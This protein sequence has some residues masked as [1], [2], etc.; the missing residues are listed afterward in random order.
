ME[1][2]NICELRA[3]I[4]RGLL[5]EA[6]PAYLKSI[7]SLVPSNAPVM[8]VRVPKIRQWVRDFCQANP[9]LTLHQSIGL[10]DLAFVDNVREE[11]LFGILLLGKFEKALP[12][13]LWQTIDRWVAKLE[14][15][16]SCDQLAMNVAASMVAKNLDLVDDLVTWAGAPQLWR[17][18]F[19]IAIGTTLNQK[20]RSFPEHTLRICSEAM[21]DEEPMVQKAVGWALR[22]A[23]RKNPDLVFG[24][25]HQ[26]KPKIS[27][28]LLRESAQKLNDSQRADLLE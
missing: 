27:R 11:V 5:A 12:P 16:E 26:W 13:R 25:L 17:R 3:V 6:D 15:W 9:D 21:T 19:A 7:T 10:L 22:E 1:P 2:S 24:F 14:N 4:K 18:R 20:G 28:R 8:G 23:S